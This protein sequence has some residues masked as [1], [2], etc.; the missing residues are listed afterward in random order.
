[1]RHRERRAWH[2]VALHEALNHPVEGGQTRVRLASGVSMRLGFGT[3]P[4]APQDAPRT[5]RRLFA[6]IQNDDPVDEHEFHPF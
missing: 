4:G 2:L 5:G 3:I 1:M 6:V